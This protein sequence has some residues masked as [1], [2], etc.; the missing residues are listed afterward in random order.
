MRIVIFTH[1]LAGDSG[2]TLV[3]GISSCQASESLLRIQTVN[4][5][6]EHLKRSGE[7]AGNEILLLLAENRDRL[8]ELT[9]LKDLLEDRRLILVVPD[10]DPATL[11]AAHLLFPRFVTP[12]S[13]QYHD[14]CSIMDRMTG[15]LPPGKGL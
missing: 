5:L 11:S 10:D 9:G 15:A 1:R 3:N 12:L 6:K 8:E 2:K 14:L 13:D 7:N 4:T